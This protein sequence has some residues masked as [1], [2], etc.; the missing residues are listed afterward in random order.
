MCGRNFLSRALSVFLLLALFSAGLPVFGEENG[1]SLG[2]ESETL[3]QSS[4][5]TEN[6]SPLPNSGQSS[7]DDILNRLDSL[8]ENWNQASQTDLKVLS[9][10]QTIIVRQN[11]LL[12]SSEK[13]LKASELSRQLE[14]DSRMKAESRLEV[15]KTV[16]IA[17][18]ILA[19]LVLIRDAVIVAVTI[20][21]TYR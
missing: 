13:S 20:A 8:V 18:G 2:A 4:T 10:A 17:G 6:L 12:E 15:W 21:T 3:K 1:S 11:S 14:R 5:D 7:A 9:D 19:A 16:G